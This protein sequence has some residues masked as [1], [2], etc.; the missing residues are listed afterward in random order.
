MIYDWRVNLKTYFQTTRPAERE[1]FAL[2]VGASV[3]YLYL[4]A[5]GVRR[6][7]PKLCKR[8]VAND[9]RFTLADLRPDLWEGD[10]T[11]LDASDD[12]QPPVGTSDDANSA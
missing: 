8:I 12:T 5:R 2:A 3:D 9:H 4:C 7:G 6:P 10:V 11:G 1:A